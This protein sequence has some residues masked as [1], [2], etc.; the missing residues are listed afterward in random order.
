MGG[1][2]RGNDRR[3]MAPFGRQECIDDS[4]RFGSPGVVDLSARG[5]APWIP[6]PDGKAGDPALVE[7]RL[8][9]FDRS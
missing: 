9:K 3:A 8:A 7:K 2:W 4:R 6:A 5:P 1:G